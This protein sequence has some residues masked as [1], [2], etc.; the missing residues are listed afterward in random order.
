MENRRD[1]VLCAHICCNMLLHFS[2][3]PATFSN[4]KQ[5]A[6]C[7]GWGEESLPVAVNPGTCSCQCPNTPGAK[8]EVE[9]AQ[10]GE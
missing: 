1:S 10:I 6:V 8:E 9:A 3:L 7:N 5:C 4:L 2:P